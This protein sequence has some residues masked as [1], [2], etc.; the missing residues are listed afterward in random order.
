MK[1]VHV[2]TFSANV[3]WKQQ[4]YHTHELSAIVI[5]WIRPARD[6]IQRGWEKAHKDRTL[7]EK[8][9]TVLRNEGSIFFRD[10]PPPQVSH[11]P[12]R[13]SLI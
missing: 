9:Q 13:N 5:A 1:K 8:L 4:E 6:H 2:N 11:D 7:P 10:E 3:F 12:V